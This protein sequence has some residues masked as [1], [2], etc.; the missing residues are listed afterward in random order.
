MIEGFSTE[1]TE[2]ISDKFRAFNAYEIF[3]IAIS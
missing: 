2:S 3:E 1:T